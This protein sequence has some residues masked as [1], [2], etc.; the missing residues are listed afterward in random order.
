MNDKIEYTDLNHEFF[1]VR[2]E[3]FPCKEEFFVDSVLLPNVDISEMKNSRAHQ[4]NRLK[5]MNKFIV[6]PI[7]LIMISSIFI[8]DKPVYSE[9]YRE[10]IN[11]VVRSGDTLWDISSRYLGSSLR[12][13]QIVD[14]NHIENPDLIFPDDV[15]QITVTRTVKYRNGLVIEEKIY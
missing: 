5:G 10:V 9:T 6:I 4:L 3:F 2:E 11:Y 15:Y 14:E 13:L 1:V 12:Y 7:M 8:F